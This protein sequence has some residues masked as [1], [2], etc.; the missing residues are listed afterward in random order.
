MILV[1]GFIQRTALF[2][3]LV[4]VAMMLC[5]ALPSRMD[6]QCICYGNKASPTPPPRIQISSVS[7][8]KFSPLVTVTRFL[9]KLVKI[10][11]IK[12]LKFS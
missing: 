7:Q 8:P 6:G 4:N 10:L 9:S 12:N 3:P 2:L 1:C 5:R 11:Q